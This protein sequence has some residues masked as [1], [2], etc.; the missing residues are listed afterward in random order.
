MRQ[1]EIHYQED[2]VFKQEYILESAV[3]KVMK[4]VTSDLAGYTVF[5]VLP[6]ISMQQFHH[7]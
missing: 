4:V 2:G 7:R 6:S 3:V 1:G 5:L